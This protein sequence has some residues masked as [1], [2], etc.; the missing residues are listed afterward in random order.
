MKGRDEEWSVR[1]GQIRNGLEK[2]RKI[3]ED[4]PHQNR[5]AYYNNSL[6]PI[7]KANKPHFQLNKQTNKRINKA[8]TF[9]LGQVA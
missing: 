7:K 3:R 9:L 8:V 6:G 1:A 5:N 4:A 2:V